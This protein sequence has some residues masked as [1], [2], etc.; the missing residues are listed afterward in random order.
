MFIIFN[1][2]NSN[3]MSWIDCVADK[4]Y[5]IFSEEPY[6][7]RRKSN[8]R[9]VKESIHKSSGYIRCMLNQKQ[10]YK[11]DI[12]AMQFIPNPNNYN[13]VDH[14]NRIRTDNRIENLRWVSR[15]SNMKNKLSHINQIY[16]YV[17]KISDN[18]FEI[19]DYGNHKFENYW[20]DV[21]EDKFYY[22]NEYQYK[23]LKICNH[24]TGPVVNVIDNDGVHCTFKI[25][26]F[27]RLY[28]III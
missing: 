8:K 5:Q 23:E 3:Q 20:Y 26:K 27:K 28:N 10:K 6:Q 4:D 11:H 9:I 14:I 22:F 24:P 18:S 2:F 13:E 16:N 7:I 19:T 21:D 1:D 17:D 15:S 12:L 25:N